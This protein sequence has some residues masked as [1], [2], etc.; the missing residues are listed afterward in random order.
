MK[1]EK[2]A[3]QEKRNKLQNDWTEISN[4]NCRFKKKKQT[5]LYNNN[6]SSKKKN[7]EKYQPHPEI[8]K[9]WLRVNPGQPH[10]WPPW[11]PRHLLPADKRCFYMEKFK[12]NS[13][14]WKIFKNGII[15]HW[16]DL[17]IFDCLN[18]HVSIKW[19][20]PYVNIFGKW[21]DLWKKTIFDLLQDN[22]L[23]L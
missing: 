23:H 16:L 21:E 22:H 8:L 11:H 12:K 4:K 20:Y 2:R 1:I 13:S 17:P 9:G 14:E 7:V 18:I 5:K 10:S 15:W 3:K 19:D 6:N